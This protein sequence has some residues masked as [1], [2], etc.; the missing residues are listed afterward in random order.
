MKHLP[1]ENGE[2][3]EYIFHPWKFFRTG[4]RKKNQ[5]FRYISTC[6]G[7]RLHLDQVYLSTVFCFPRLQGKQIGRNG[8]SWEE[9]PFREKMLLFP[10]VA[11]SLDG[12]PANLTP[13]S[14]PAQQVAIKGIL[15]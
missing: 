2:A 9:L 6:L 12:S 5:Q 11:T 1:G 13:S 14:V 10:L 8:K 4:Y 3:L 7:G 15:S